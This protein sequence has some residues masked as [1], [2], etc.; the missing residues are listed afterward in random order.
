M[1]D[2]VSEA[3]EQLEAISREAEA[4]ATRVALD[5]TA[6]TGTGLRDRIRLVR[7]RLAVSAGELARAAALGDDITDE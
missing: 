1:A 5:L 3:L 7:Q 6:A 2:D 4:L